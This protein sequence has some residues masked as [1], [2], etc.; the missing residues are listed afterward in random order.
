MPLLIENSSNISYQMSDSAVLEVLGAFIRET[1][2]SQ[3]KTQEDVAIAAGIQRMTLVRIEKGSGGTM[4]TLI[5]LHSSQSY[6]FRELCA[7]LAQFHSSQSYPFRELCALL[8]QFTSL[9]QHLQVH[10]SQS[11]PFREL[12]ALLAQFTSLSQH[13]QVRG[14]S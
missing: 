10:S 12:C 13:L 2:L 8:A 5:R 1:R 9:S 14:S 7:L 3:N 6:P 11:Y 4:A